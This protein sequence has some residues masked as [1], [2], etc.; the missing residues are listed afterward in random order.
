[1][2]LDIKSVITLKPY[3]AYRNIALT[4]QAIGKIS[5][6]EGDAVKKAKWKVKMFARS[7]MLDRKCNIF[8]W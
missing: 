3:E 8:I 2:V 5:L 4:T 1:M 7:Q 6:A